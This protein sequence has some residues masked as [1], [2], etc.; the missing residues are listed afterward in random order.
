[1]LLAYSLHMLLSLFVCA[2]EA[3]ICIC[4]NSI[5]HIYFRVAV[6]APVEPGV[7]KAEAKPG[8]DGTVH[9]RHLL[10]RRRPHPLGRGRAGVRARDLE[11]CPA[12]LPAAGL[13]RAAGGAAW[14]RHAGE[15][16]HDVGEWGGVFL[17]PRI[18]HGCQF[19][20]RYTLVGT[21]IK[22]WTVS[23]RAESSVKLF[24]FKNPFRPWWVVW[25]YS[26]FVCFQ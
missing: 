6:W 14:D 7:G 24:S 22:K 2:V 18:H 15:P 19:N 5:K 1:M 9:R 23:L 10:L 3:F 17:Q 16:V 4:L 12:D 13:R 25:G 11:P 26:S 21:Q 20:V 8:R